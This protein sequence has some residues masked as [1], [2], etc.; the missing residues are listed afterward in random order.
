MS[1]H[2]NKNPGILPFLKEIGNYKFIAGLGLGFLLGFIYGDNTFVVSKTNSKT[3]KIEFKI[4]KRQIACKRKEIFKKYGS[5]Q[6]LIEESF[7]R[8]GHFKRAYI[9]TIDD[10]TDTAF[11]DDKNIERLL[12]ELYDKRKDICPRGFDLILPEVNVVA[13]PSPDSSNISG[14]KHLHYAPLPYSSKRKGE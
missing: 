12:K 4:G 2:E 14:M 1:D 3:E 7:D 13:I 6:L 10:M 5:R 11:Y 9:Q 8:D